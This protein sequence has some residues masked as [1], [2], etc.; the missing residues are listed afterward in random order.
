[1]VSGVLD[2]ADHTVGVAIV[3]AVVA[4]VLGGFVGRCK[5]RGGGRGG[6]GA[7]AGTIV[8]DVYVA[9][10]AQAP[11]IRAVISGGLALGGNS[12]TAVGAVVA[13]VTGGRVGG[14]LGWLLGGP[15]GRVGG[16]RYR[17]VARLLA[18]STQRGRPNEAFE[19]AAVE[20]VCARAET[21]AS[22]AVAV[23]VA[24]GG[25]WGFAFGGLTIIYVAH[26]RIG[27]AV[28]GA[29]VAGMFGGKMG[30][31][32]CGGASG[33]RTRLEGRLDGGLECGF[34]GRLGGRRKRGLRS[35][36][37]SGLRSWV[38]SGLSSRGRGWARSGRA[39]SAGST[40]DVAFQANASELVVARGSAFG[41]RSVAAVGAVVA[42]VRGRHVCWS[43]CRQGTRDRGGLSRRGRGG[44]R[45]GVRGRVRSGIWGMGS[46]CRKRQQQGRA[47][48]ALY[49]SRTLSTLA[50]LGAYRYSQGV[51]K[52]LG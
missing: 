45:G 5:R 39:R 14:L 23:A 41:G 50:T 4:R 9:L 21:A 33:I 52:G 12:V 29:V 31:L 30:R 47:S 27:V 10:T 49:G 7:A 19:A 8:I 40:R 3:G 48:Q 6:R 15:N 36:V 1:V 28:M 46:E 43:S 51:G 16:R 24:F 11:I 2:N 20:L 17:G 13:R 34:D 42:G 25:V 35:W 22:V 26:G 38:S 37:S 44:V 18:V 32:K